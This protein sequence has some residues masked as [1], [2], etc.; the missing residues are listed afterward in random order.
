MNGAGR[1]TTC[2]LS[3]LAAVG[4]TFAAAAGPVSQAAVARRAVPATVD[5]EASFEYL[6]G[7]SSHLLAGDH[8]KQLAQLK[9]RLDA[10][11]AE[12]RGIVGKLDEAARQTA[13]AE[14]AGD[15]AKVQAPQGTIAGLQ[16]S[17]AKVDNEIQQLLSEIQ[18]LRDDENR[19]QDDAKRA[20]ETLRKFG[21]A[22]TETPP[23][24]AYVKTLSRAARDA[25]LAKAQ[26]GHD[27]LADVVRVA[28]L[29]ARDA[30][31]ALADAADKQ[32]KLLEEKEKLRAAQTRLEGV[33][34]PSPT[35]TRA[36]PR[37]MALSPRS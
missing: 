17:L 5:S 18:K 26:R 21:L 24:D 16:K 7:L 3:A 14:M 25:S 23:R 34:A 22:L 37:P 28:E 29:A 1:R 27:A 8:E 36:V 20:A 11:L 30:S 12:K 9:A 15:H 31:A 32:R 13:G 4:F 2:T 6:I 33:K 35:P 19:A 10:L